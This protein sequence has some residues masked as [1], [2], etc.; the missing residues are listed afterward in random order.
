MS[1]SAALWGGAGHFVLADVDAKVAE[2]E[3]AVLNTFG[4]F[5]GFALSFSPTE[6]IVVATSLA[7]NDKT[8]FSAPSSRLRPS[9]TGGGDSRSRSLRDPVPEQKR[10]AEMGIWWSNLAQ[11]VS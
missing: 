10:Q 3:V 7:E 4:R 5:S 11:G 2:L 1:R 8:T 9:S 6:G